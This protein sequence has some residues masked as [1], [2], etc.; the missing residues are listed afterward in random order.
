M[1]RLKRYA[2]LIVRVGV[3]VQ[4]GQTLFVNGQVEHAEFARA[5]T[6]AG[7]EAGARY[8]DVRYIDQTCAAR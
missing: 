5:L 8:V 7:Y 1:D 4:P 6:R 3:N 2:E